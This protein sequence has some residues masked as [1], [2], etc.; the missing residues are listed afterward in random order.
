[1]KIAHLVSTYPPYKGGMGNVCFK[2]AEGLAKFGHKIT[3]FTPFYK[4][5]HSEHQASDVKVVYL[6][7]FF[8]MGNA[9]F[10]PQILSFLKGFDV[11]HLH[12]PFIGGAEKILSAKKKLP[13]LI[14]QYHMD[15]IDTGFRGLFFR[16]YQSIFLKKMVRTAEKILVSSFDYLEYSALGKV[17]KAAKEKFE[18]L[19]LGVDLDVF[20]PQEK[21]KILKEKYNLGEKRVILFV[22]ALDRAHY[23]KGLSILLEALTKTPKNV[24]LIVVGEGDLKKD[25]EDL[26]QELKISERTVF[27]GNVGLENLVRFYNLADVFVLPSISSS[28]A[29]GLVLL[30]AGACAKPILVSDLPGP[31]TLVK[32]GTNG[33]LIKPGDVNDLAE[34]IKLIFRT[35]PQEMGER[36]RKMVLEK[37]D[38]RVLAKKLEAIYEKII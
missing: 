37:Y 27:V 30:E 9:A 16:L 24:I 4:N 19:P 21:D 5:T 6:K 13:P 1:M 7:P 26:A 2:E 18:E 33:F 25:Y 29:F 14:V 38:S 3:V 10:V 23:F 12:W 32:E 34:K 31:R 8:K 17:Y 22:G 20:S 15:L 36:G 28:E 11:V 35:Q